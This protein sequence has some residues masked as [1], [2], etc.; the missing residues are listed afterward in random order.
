MNTTELQTALV[1]IGWPIK[2]DGD[3]GAITRQAVRDFQA[4]LSL[5]YALTIDGQ[6]GSATYKALDHSLSLGG[7]CGSNFYF[8]EFASKG[9]G[10]IRTS[11]DL[12]AGLDRYRWKTGPVKIISG[13]RDP[14]HNTRVGGKP[15]SQHP[16]GT[17][18][19]IEQRVSVATARSFGFRGIGYQ[20]ATGLVRHVDMRPGNVVVWR[21]S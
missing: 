19:D 14:A 13:Y 20:G 1:R 5:G 15:R 8:R 3:Y 17:A 18:A 9:N 12:V 7:K 21:Y 6:A 4:G 10:W 11:R 2:T 16:L